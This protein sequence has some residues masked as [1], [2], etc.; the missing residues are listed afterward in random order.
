[1]KERNVTFDGFRKLETDYILVYERVIIVIMLHDF[2]SF[3][4]AF[5]YFTI[6]AN[7]WEFGGRVTKTCSPATRMAMFGQRFYYNDYVPTK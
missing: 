2:V 6:M 1:M 4:Q 5:E 3:D 7:M